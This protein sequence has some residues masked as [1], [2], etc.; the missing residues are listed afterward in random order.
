M[1][2]ILGVSI[3]ADEAVYERGKSAKFSIHDQ[4]DQTRIHAALKAFAG[5]IGKAKRRALSPS[6]S[7][8]L[9]DSMAV[10]MDSHWR[11]EKLHRFPI[12]LMTYSD[13]FDCVISADEG[14]FVEYWTPGEQF[15]LPT[16]VPGLRSFKSPT[17][18]Y[19]FKKGRRTAIADARQIV[20]EPEGSE[21]VPTEPRKL[22]GRILHVLHGHG[23]LDCRRTEP[24]EVCKGS[25]KQSIS[26]Y[27]M[28]L[29]IDHIMTALRMLF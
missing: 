15:E 23:K 18:L 9:Y 1:S 24:A 12:H 4:H 16:N 14:S 29:N 27:H 21:Y 5:Y 25:R 11:L 8:R 19:E 7:I 28:D 17:D 2:P 13:R 22:C 3:S 20:V 26:S 10:E 6:Q